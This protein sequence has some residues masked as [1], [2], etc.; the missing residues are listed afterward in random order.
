MKPIEATRR[1]FLAF[2]GGAAAA[3]PSAAQA[4]IRSLDLGA[5]GVRLP[6][7]SGSGPLKSAVGCDTDLHAGDGLGDDRLVI[8]C[9]GLPIGG[10]AVLLVAHAWIA[11]IVGLRPSSRGVEPG[12]RAISTGSAWIT[13]KPKERAY[14]SAS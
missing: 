2:L 1:R 4:T 13:W 5:I 10:L 12:M 3:G 14:Q 6:D 8:V 7:G 9:A 11:F